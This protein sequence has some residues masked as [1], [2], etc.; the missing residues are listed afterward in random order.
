MADVDQGGIS[1]ITHALGVGPS[2][3]ATTT[4]WRGTMFITMP[5]TYVLDTSVNFVGVNVAGAVT[6]VLPPVLVPAVPAI[7][8]PGGY[9]NNVIYITDV[10]GHANT[11][12]IIV[13]PAAGQTII[14]LSSI[15][16]GGKYGTVSLV[17]NN[18]AQG[19]NQ[20]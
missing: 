15:Q 17:P 18:T 12:P 9:I 14:G 4:L 13:Q 7:A 10:G 11:N 6:I 8:I 2:V 16:I 3:G 5:G 20:L 19:Y 1:R